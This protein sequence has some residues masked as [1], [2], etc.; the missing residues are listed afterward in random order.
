MLSSPKRYV[1][2]VS[3]NLEIIDTDI[4]NIVIQCRSCSKLVRINTYSLKCLTTCDVINFSAMHT[5]KGFQFC[6]FI[7]V[8]LCYS[9]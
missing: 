3:G 6:G 8:V 4:Y 1:G 2:D 5:G 7:G 9:G